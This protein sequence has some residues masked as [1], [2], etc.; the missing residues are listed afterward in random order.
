MEQ[1]A[2]ILLNIEYVDCK[3]IHQQPKHTDTYVLKRGQQLFIYSMASNRGNAT[4]ES[5]EFRN[6]LYTV[7]RK[8]NTKHRSLNI[9]LTI[10]FI[11][12]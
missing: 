11:I 3:L 2:F 9:I 7:H 4:I 1:L 6:V 12:Y 5:Y 10:V 8:L